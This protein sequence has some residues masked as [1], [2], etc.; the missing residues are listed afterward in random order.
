MGMATTTSSAARMLLS[1]S[2]PSADG[3]MNSNFLAR[4]ILPCNSS[5]ATI[6]AS[7]P[8]PTITLDLTQPPNPMQFP[9]IPFN[10]FPLPFLNQSHNIGPDPSNPATAL[11]T[12]IFNHGLYNQSKFSGHQMSQEIDQGSHESQPSLHQLNETANALATDPNLAA[13][14]IAAISSL[15]VAPSPNNGNGCNSSNNNS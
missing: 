4:T 6:S 2:M 14:L 8:F 7:A 9:R 15:I 1:G 5:M 12:Q 10:Q 13:S 3:I 11:L